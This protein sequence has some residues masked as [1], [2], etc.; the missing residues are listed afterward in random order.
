MSESA[1]GGLCID[2][3]LT[4]SNNA[5]PF[6]PTNDRTLRSTRLTC[7]SSSNSADSLAA[8][9][10]TGPSFCRRTF[11]QFVRKALVVSFT[12]VVGDEL[13]QSPTRVRFASG[14]TRCRRS[15]F[16]E[17]TNRSACALQF[18]ALGG[19]RTTRTPAVKSHCSTALLHFGSRSQTKTRK[20]IT[21]LCALT[22][23]LRRGPHGSILRKHFEWTDVCDGDRVCGLDHLPLAAAGFWRAVVGGTMPFNRR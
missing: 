11:D 7:S 22:W 15:S 23:Y 4:F 14:T 16:T 13:S 10:S 17:R 6:C 2:G 5:Y 12:M 8:T 20:H 21:T 1:L 19:V 3:K 18:G 9:H